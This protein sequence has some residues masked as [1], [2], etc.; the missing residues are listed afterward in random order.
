L[1]TPWFR[2]FLTFEPATALAE[3]RCPVLALNGEKDTQVD[4]ELNLPAIEKALKDG[5]NPPFRGIV[6]PNLNHLF[7]TSESGA[8]SE[9]Q[10]IEETMAP[11]M[12]ELLTAWIHEQVVDPG[13]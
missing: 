5:H 2:F 11:R 13:R 6:L 12:L 8:V 1:T 3:V 10:E 4:P 9:Y 7:Q